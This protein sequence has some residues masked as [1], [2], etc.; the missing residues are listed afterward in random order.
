MIFTELVHVDPIIIDA[1]EF[2]MS[3]LNGV[4]D[5][6]EK[7][8]VIGKLYVDLLKKRQRN[9]EMWFLGARNDLFRCH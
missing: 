3:A 1:R 5:P 7:R 4:T 6:E 9:I 2:F 8:K